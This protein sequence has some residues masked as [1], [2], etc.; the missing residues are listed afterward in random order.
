MVK[1]NVTDP[2][3]ICN[4]LG[5]NFN[6]KKATTGLIAIKKTAMTHGFYETKLTIEVKLPTGHPDL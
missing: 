4:I 6:P 2:I 3:M 5:K 1:I